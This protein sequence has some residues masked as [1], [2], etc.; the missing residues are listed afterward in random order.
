MDKQLSFHYFKNRNFFKINYFFKIQ[1]MKYIYFLFIAL[2][3]IIYLLHIYTSYY[4][5]IEFTTSSNIQSD[6][7]KKFK[8]N[9]RSL[10]FN[11]YYLF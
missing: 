11:T 3:I 4:I 5:I 9:K 6:R 1:R 2:P 8:K 7:N 10:F